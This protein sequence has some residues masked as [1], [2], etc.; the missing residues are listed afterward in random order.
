MMKMEVKYVTYRLGAK[1]VNQ[2]K[3]DIEL[4]IWLTCWIITWNE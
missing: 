1:A 2:I 3:I 4:R